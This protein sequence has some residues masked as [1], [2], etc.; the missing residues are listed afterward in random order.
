MD[1]GKKGEKRIGVATK[2]SSQLD[3]IIQIFESSES[4]QDPTSITAC[5]A[6]LKDLLGLERGSELFY[7][8]N[9]LMKNRANK[10]TFVALEEPEL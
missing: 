9:R 8:A 7:K 10:I 3:R 1:R 2:L 5:V 4:A 6:K